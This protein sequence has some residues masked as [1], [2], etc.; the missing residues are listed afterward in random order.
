MFSQTGLRTS[1]R[2]KTSKEYNVYG[3]ATL[4]SRNRYIIV[5]TS[6]GEIMDQ[7]ELEA[8]DMEA[9]S[10]G[11]TYIV[12]DEN[13]NEIRRTNSEALASMTAAGH[14]GTYELKK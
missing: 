11:R 13:G 2:K 6:K 14:H 4:I 3:K 10:G 8:K 1:Y 7:K 9:V 5:Y 12:Y